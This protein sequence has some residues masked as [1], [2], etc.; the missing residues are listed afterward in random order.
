MDVV[1]AGFDIEAACLPWLEDDSDVKAI[2]VDIELIKTLQQ[3]LHATQDDIEERDAFFEWSRKKKMK[4][5]VE[6][7]D[8]VDSNP[9]DEVHKH[10]VAVVAKLG[11]I[12]HATLHMDNPREVVLN[13][14]KD[15]RN[16]LAYCSHY[17][18]LIENWE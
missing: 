1:E 7:M 16:L 17:L 6:I 14:V 5:L 2:S 18:D 11:D 10:L 3:T 8:A 9:T 4:A 12:R 15:V 13:R